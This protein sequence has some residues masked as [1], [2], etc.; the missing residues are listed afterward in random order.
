MGFLGIFKKKRQKI[1]NHRK[2]LRKQD[3]FLQVRELLV[4]EFKI[5]NKEK[6]KL[7]SRLK[8]DLGLDSIDAIQVV[9]VLEREFNFEIPDDDVERINTVADIIEYLL[10]RLTRRA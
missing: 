7:E 2:E 5:E 4:S 3:L 1:N 8:E 10:T 9:M 6:I